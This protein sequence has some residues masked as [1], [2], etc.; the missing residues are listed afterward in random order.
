[1][2]DIDK[3]IEQRI[4]DAKN[5]TKSSDEV[6]HIAWL[7]RGIDIWHESGGKMGN[8]PDDAER[9]IIS[10]VT[11][12]I[13]TAVREARIDENERYLKMLETG[14]WRSFG[15]EVTER[16]AQLKEDK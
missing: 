6:V 13:S 9:Y 8:S 7:A 2:S 16:L 5:N 11:R 4:Q 15:I 14:K 1:M 3:L 10:S 12:L